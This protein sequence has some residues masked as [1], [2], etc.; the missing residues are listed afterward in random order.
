MNDGD[1]EEDD[2]DG[3]IMS[4]KSWYIVAIAQD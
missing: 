2:D 1:E 4:L 3:I